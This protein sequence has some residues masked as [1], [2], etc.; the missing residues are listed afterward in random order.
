MVN[1]MS[2]IG[3]IFREAF[4]YADKHSTCRKVHVG[5]CFI[6]EDG[7]KYYS[8]NNGGK[9]N[10]NELGYCYKA[11]VTGIYEST[12][13]T[14]KYCQSTHSEINMLKI[15]KENNVDP[16][17]GT[18]YISRYPCRNCLTKC[19]EAGIKH[20]KFCGISEGTTPEE[21]KRDCLENNVEY[22]W[23]PEYDFE[24]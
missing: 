3:T 16:S 5:S 6:T 1:N 19:I 9:Q 13:A 23:Y 22:E 24:F 7:T 12:E 14:R 20:I 2:N 18:L 8:C 11:K 15:L 21:N 17:K 4:K 10:C